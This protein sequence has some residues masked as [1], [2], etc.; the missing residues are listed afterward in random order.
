ME[1]VLEVL[2]EDVFFVSCV[3]CHGEVVEEDKNSLRCLEI[4]I[5]WFETDGDGICV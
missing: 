5:N 2:C 3:T 4:E 1:I